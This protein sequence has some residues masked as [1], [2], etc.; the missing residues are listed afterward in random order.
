MSNQ[1]GSTFRGKIPGDGLFSAFPGE[2]ETLPGDKIK[3]DL[4]TGKIKTEA[5]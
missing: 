4:P 2:Q 5:L 3:S 1:H